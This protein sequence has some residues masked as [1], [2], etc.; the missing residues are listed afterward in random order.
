MTT[1]QTQKP[2]KLMLDTETYGT[3]PG[4][5]IM[6]IS[7][8]SF[9][10]P[11]GAPHH[12]FHQ[13][14]KRADQDYLIEEETTLA[15]WAAQDQEVFKAMT[16]GSMSLREALKD[17]ASW[18]KG[19]KQPVEIWC[20]GATFDAPILEAAYAAYCMEIPWGFRDVRCYRTLVSE[21]GYVVDKPEFTGSKHNS[22]HDAIHQATYAELILKTIH[23]M[24]AMSYVG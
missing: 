4:C 21:F 1:E 22:L 20:N 2:I 15:W 9:M 17:F 10:V 19:F 18:I 24:K 3:Q 23:R 12:Y 5:K 6:S 16:S 13:L 14:V 11:A 7:A 8:V